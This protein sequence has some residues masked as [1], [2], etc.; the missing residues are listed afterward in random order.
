ML[1]RFG[2]SYPGQLLPVV[3]ASTALRSTA[4][5]EDNTHDCPT[6]SPGDDSS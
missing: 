2:A 1:H 6:L 4:Y 3:P 5:L